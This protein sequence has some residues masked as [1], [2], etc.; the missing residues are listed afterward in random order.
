MGKVISFIGQKGGSCKS[1]SCYCSLMLLHLAMGEKYKIGA[2]NT[3]MQPSLTRLINKTDRKADL[4][5]LLKEGDY[6]AENI[7][8]TIKKA[9][10]EYD[11]LFIDT[12]GKFEGDS[13]PAIVNSTHVL[14]PFQ[15]TE[16]DIAP[17]IAFFSLLLPS[18]R[19]KY[20]AG[21]KTAIFPARVKISSSHLKILELIPQFKNLPPDTVMFKSF[22]SDKMIYQNPVPNIQKILES[23]DFIEYSKE[24]RNFI[25]S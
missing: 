6:S 2:I 15:P 10:Q 17:T 5:P 24:F 7:G 21:F 20:K 12:P 11:V 18:I 8:N 9:R 13:I 19:E 23:D 14:I 16:N 4:I 25:M 1:T 3:D 22:I